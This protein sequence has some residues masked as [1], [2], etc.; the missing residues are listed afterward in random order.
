M[1]REVVRFV[2]LEV[3]VGFESALLVS[4]RY[5]DGKAVV[6]TPWGLVAHAPVELSVAALAVNAKRLKGAVHDAA[7]LHRRYWLQ[8]EGAHR[9]ADWRQPRRRL[10]GLCS[11]DRGLPALENKTG[12][13]ADSAS[14]SKPSL[15]SP[16][17]SMTAIP[18][19]LKRLSR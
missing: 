11:G 9:K 14:S 7:C 5:G 15:L 16:L 8:K 19:N 13:R 6:L 1:G 18:P 10:R 17:R 2:Q 4:D 3:A 12:R